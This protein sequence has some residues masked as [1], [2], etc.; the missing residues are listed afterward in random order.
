M[1]TVT[2][3]KTH[4][5][6]P[7]EAHKR[8]DELAA[9]FADKLSAS[10]VWSDESTATIESKKVN[11]TLKLAATELVIDLNLPWYLA[12]VKGSVVRAIEDNLQK[13]GFV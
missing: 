5:L 8:I 7:T 10:I 4:A 1:A 13:K 6:T 11:G 12:A 9:A 3:K 2:I